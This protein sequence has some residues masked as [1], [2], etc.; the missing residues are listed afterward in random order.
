MGKL[1]R[2]LKATVLKEMVAMMENVSRKRNICLY[3]SEIPTS[4]LD[5]YYR[6]Y[7]ISVPHKISFIMLHFVSLASRGRTSTNDAAGS[8]P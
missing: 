1:K 3:K 7:F 8:K 5:A 4:S 6:D 2:L